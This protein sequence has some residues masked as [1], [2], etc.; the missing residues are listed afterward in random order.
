MKNTLYKGKF[1][2]IPIGDSSHISAGKLCSNAALEQP[3][4]RY[5]T[6]WHH[7]LLAGHGHICALQDTVRLWPKRR[8]AV[9]PHGCAASK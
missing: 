5:A 9:V 6:R 4:A 2:F 3:A 7:Y 8:V 1:I